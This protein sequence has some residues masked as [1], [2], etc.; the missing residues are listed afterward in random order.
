MSQSEKIVIYRANSRD[1]THLVN[2]IDGSSTKGIH[3]QLSI[4]TLD[5]PLINISKLDQ[6]LKQYSVLNTRS[7][8][9]QYLY[10]YLIKCQP[11][12]MM[13]IDTQQ[14]A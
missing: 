4:N 10:Q 6:H 11:T 12:C 5:Q 3:S 9:D 1:A 7:T 2:V 13:L 8:L 14:C